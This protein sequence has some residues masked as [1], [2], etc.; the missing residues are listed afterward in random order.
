[1]KSAEKMA[2]S[3]PLPAG[4]RAQQIP[5]GKDFQSVVERTLQACLDVFSPVSHER[6]E[7]DPWDGPKIE[8]PPP[9]VWLSEAASQP[10]EAIEDMDEKYGSQCNK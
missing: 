7:T 10:R 2:Q 9:L 4:K 8:G 3:D 1:M 6:K 5:T